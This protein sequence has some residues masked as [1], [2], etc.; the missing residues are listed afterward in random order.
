MSSAQ[1]LLPALVQ[2]YEDLAAQG[3]IAQQGWGPA[4]VSYAIDLE[5][6]GQ[7]KQII[8][9]KTEQ[10]KKKKT[11]LQSQTMQVP[12]PVKRS[13]GIRANFLC[14][15]SG[16]I[17]GCSIKGKPER[18]ADCFRACKQLHE[19]LLAD[20]QHPAAIAILLFF[21]NWQPEQTR[22]HPLLQENLED[23]LGGASLVFRY[24]GEYLHEIPEIRTAWMKYY[25][26]PL[27]GEQQICLVTGNLA[28]TARLHPSIKGIRGAQSSGASLVSYNAPAFCSYGKEQGMNAPTSEY[29]AFAY[30]AALNYLIT[31][32]KYYIGDTALLCWASGGEP[33]Y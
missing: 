6:N 8:S 31:Q 23:I 20:V 1:A 10:I 30:G 25:N 17:F 7:I 3:K 21:A 26:K 16:Y 22:T 2:Y 19:E 32:S 14:D 29:A 5:Q 18:D 11:V 28:Q 15:S 13:S 24:Q 27:Y 12:E 9:V 33:E 4:K